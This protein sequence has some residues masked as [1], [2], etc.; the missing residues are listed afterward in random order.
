MGVV[1]DVDRQAF[2]VDLAGVVDPVPKQVTLTSFSTKSF[3]N[4]GVK[5]TQR[6]VSSQGGR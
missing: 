2:E 5:M 4:I 1:D 3:K 6:R